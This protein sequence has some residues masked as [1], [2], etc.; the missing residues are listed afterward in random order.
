MSICEAD[1][2]RFGRA[3]WQDLRDKQATAVNQAKFGLSRILPTLERL[4]G[5]DCH[6]LEVGAGRMLLSAYLASKGIRITALEP[7][8][9]DFQW[10]DAIQRDVLAY[11][12]Q[13]GIA[14]ERVDG[15][16]EEYVAPA[17]Y[18][19]IFSIHVLEHMRD[20][21]RA[22]KNMYQSLKTPGVMLALCPNYDVPFEPHLGIWLL[23]RDKSFNG[24]VYRRRIA[25]KQELWDRLSFVRYSALRRFLDEQRIQHSFNSSTLHDMFLQLGKDRLFYERMPP[26]I[27]GTYKVLVVSRLISLLRWIPLRLQ[28]PMEL[29]VIK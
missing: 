13:E 5:V 27:R 4:R 14:F 21:R 15:L 28:T 7:L 25:A 3:I 16:A 17:R 1:L 9:A 20:P 8:T 23:G 26:F 12:A 29:L 11:C 2:E 10:F 24:K 22:L 6:V 18:D 19:L